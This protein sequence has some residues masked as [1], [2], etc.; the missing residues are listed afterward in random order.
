[1]TEEDREMLRS[2]QRG[3]AHADAVVALDG[4]GHYS[5]I[6]EAVDAAPDGRKRR[7]VIYVKSGLYKENVDLKRKK[8]NIMLVGEG[9]G[10][11]II[12]SNRNFMQGWTTFRTAT[13]GK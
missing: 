10:K 9:I 3:A 1:M 13:V 6:S 5:S 11:T 12:T 7:Y 2:R 4:S 8:T